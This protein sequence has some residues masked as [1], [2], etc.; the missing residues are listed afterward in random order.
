MIGD[1]ALGAGVA[2]FGTSHVLCVGDLMLDRFVHGQV[3]RISP[4]API[5]VFRVGRETAVPGGAGNVVRNIVALGASASFLSVVGD[6]PEGRA[7]AAM[8]A[9]EAGV[10]ATVLTERDRPTTVKIR[11][12]AEGQQLLRADRESTRPVIPKTAAELARVVAEAA[13]RAD[14][15]VISDYAK[16]VVTDTVLEAVASAAKANG[17]PL[18]VD[19][20]G[21]DFARYR[22]ATLMTP[23]RRELASAVRADGDDEA[24][25]TAAAQRALAEWDVEAILITLGEEGMSLVTRDGSARHLPAEV[26]EVYD[27]SGA[28]DTVLA[29]CAAAL[30]RGLPLLDAARL[31]NLAAGIVVGRV[32]TAVVYKDDL[33][34]AIHSNARSETEAKVVSLAAA[35]ERVDRWR[36]AG[37]RVGFT[38]GCFDLLH[39]GHV[40]MLGGARAAADRLVVGLNSDQSVRRLKGPERPI[41]G[42]AARALV[43]ASLESVDLVVVFR[44]DT[45]LALI[46]ALRPEVL[47]KG[48]DYRPD[49]VVGAETV[50]G[51]GGKVV[52]VPLAPGHHST[53][54][55]IARIAR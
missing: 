7:L 6:D 10:E 21:R 30:G 42:E 43:L 17:K 31:A 27:V 12:V 50:R 49:E 8:I 47:A 34:R 52:I 51:Y 25:L 53:S 22:G 28:G 13:P 26:R 23:N 15:I 40:A 14:V 36:R 20:K 3:D 24:R 11:Y 1:R 29:T 2:G 39:P 37:E 48:A 9:A 41:Q 18:V 33:M 32:G 19:P 35:R 55:T 54:D 46:E 45:P 44:E 38:N 5:P 16:G 4:E